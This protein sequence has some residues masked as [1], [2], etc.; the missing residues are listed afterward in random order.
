MGRSQP[1]RA[2][3]FV[4]VDE[5]HVVGGKAFFDCQIARRNDARFNFGDVAQRCNWL[6]RQPIQYDECIVLAVITKISN[7][8]GQD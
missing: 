8:N 2:W 4:V 6:T 7:G 5:K 1:A 3:H